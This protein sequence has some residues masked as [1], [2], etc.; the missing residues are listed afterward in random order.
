MKLDNYNTSSSKKNKKTILINL[1]LYAQQKKLFLNVEFR[2]T[3]S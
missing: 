2:Q 3:G 1:N